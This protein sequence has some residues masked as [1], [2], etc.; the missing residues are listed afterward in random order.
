[1]ASPASL[2]RYK[3]TY[4]HLSWPWFQFSLRALC[5]CWKQN[6]WIHE[7][8]V[9][10]H[11]C[12]PQKTLEKHG[13]TSQILF[14]LSDFFSYV[15]MILTMQSVSLFTFSSLIV[16]RW[17][18]ISTGL[19]IVNSGFFP[20]LATVGSQP[21]IFCAKLGW[22]IP[23]AYSTLISIESYLPSHLSYHFVRS[24]CSSSVSLHPHYP[25]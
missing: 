15:S 25:K 9:C 5:L 12:L 10:I 11:V 4:V 6:M 19:F 17:A 1:M 21:I 8:A 7:Q 18:D 23:H 3:I 2:I 13:V 22:F 14:C 24:F 20:C 16:E